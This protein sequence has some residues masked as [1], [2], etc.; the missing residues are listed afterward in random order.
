M[1]ARTVEVMS[2]TDGHYIVLVP[3]FGHLNSV[4]IYLL[5]I[6]CIVV[7]KINTTNIN[8]NYSPVSKRGWISSIIIKYE[9]TEIAFVP[10]I[11]MSVVATNVIIFKSQLLE[12]QY[13]RSICTCKAT[14]GRL[15]LYK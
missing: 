3:H 4:H 2:H 1:L 14:I 11:F 13:A 9:F 10:L 5:Y 7:K 8:T 12:L 15:K 6:S